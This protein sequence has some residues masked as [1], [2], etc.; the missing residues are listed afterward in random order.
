M[1]EENIQN[2]TLVQFILYV[3]ILI[4][5]ILSTHY[6]LRPNILY[7]KKK[8]NIQQNLKL[9]RAGVGGGVV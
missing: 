4:C 9:E 6:Y 8:K 5:D 1:E 7:K 2:Y 3:K